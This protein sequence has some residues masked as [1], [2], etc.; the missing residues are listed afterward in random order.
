[1]DSP[2][3]GVTLEV[4]TACTF[5]RHSRAFQYTPTGTSPF[6]WWC[7]VLRAGSRDGSPASACR[8]RS[9]R[10]AR[11]RG[12]R[13]GDND[14]GTR[15][16]AAGAQASPTV[17]LGHPLSSDPS[18]NQTADATVGIGLRIRQHFHLAEFVRRR[19]GAS[20]PAS[21]NGSASQ[22]SS[23]L[24]GN[25]QLFGRPTRTPAGHPDDYMCKQIPDTP[26]TRVE[27]S[28]WFRPAIHHSTTCRWGY[29]HTASQTT[30]SAHHRILSRFSTSNTRQYPAQ[31]GHGTSCTSARHFK[32]TNLLWTEWG[33]KGGPCTIHVDR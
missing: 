17:L 26:T 12:C 1:M 13:N 31:Y 8:L 6:S 29:L 27:P 25:L 9:Q 33:S 19:G 23:S 3:G 24:R 20:Q 14:V 22:I 28:W 30:C 4:T 15:R 11:P 7:A 16:V 2:D 10:V 21:A 18:G 5:Q 32:S